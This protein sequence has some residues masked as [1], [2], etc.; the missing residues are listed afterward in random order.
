MKK[1]SLL[2]A[3][4]MVMATLVPAF[5]VAEA[6]GMP[7]LNTTDEIK[8]TYAV[9]DDYEMTQFLADKFHEKHPNITIEV[10]QLGGTDVY[11]ANLANLAANNEFPDMFQHLNLDTCILNGWFGDITPYWESDP[12]TA[13]YYDSLKKVGYL[14]G[15]RTF[16]MAAEYLPI[17]IYLD[18][19][20]FEK[21]NIPMPDADWTY[22]EMLKLM[23]ECT[24][25]ENGIWG[26]NSFLGLITIGPIAL[27]DGA[28]AE[29]GWDGDSYHFESGWA[30]AI[31]TEAEYQRLGYR[32]IQASEAWAAVAGSNE[33]WPGASGHVAIQHDAWWT[34]NNIYTQSDTLERGIK[35]VPYAPPASETVENSNAVSFIDFGAISSTTKYPREA[36]EALK[37]MTWGKDGWLARCEGFES[38]V[39]A[40]GEKIYRMPNCLPLSNNEEV[41]AAYRKLF[42]DSAYWDGFFANARRPVS[43]GGVAIPG[44]NTF[45]NEVYFNGEYNGVVGMEAAVFQGVADPYD[46]TDALNEAGRR[47]YD[48]VMEEFTAVYGEAK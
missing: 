10:L 40:A 33:V 27:T 4:V 19:T 6:G 21:L 39:N 20:V 24:S 37:F 45:L 12:E 29:F 5:A 16:F 11:M 25:P 32:A 1:L 14:D 9:W 34:M 23:E 22:E 44:F 15:K 2:L 42:D 30:D 17:T 13:E 46:Y 28:L 7:A 36:Y 8:L 35:M 48:Q 3:L 31:A 41:W 38:L 47:Y 18:Q 26:Y 43:L